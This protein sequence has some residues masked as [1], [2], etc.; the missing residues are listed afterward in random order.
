MDVFAWMW[1]PQSTLDGPRER[2]PAACGK[3]QRRRSTDRPEAR[4]GQERRH[5]FIPERG[6]D[7]WNPQTAGG[8]PRENRVE[9][10]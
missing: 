3:G 1:L 10:D 8:E 7:V 6:V 9:W 4:A 2:S 5:P